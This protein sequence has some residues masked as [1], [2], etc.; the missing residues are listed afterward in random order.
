MKIVFFFPAWTPKPELLVQIF[1]KKTVLAV[2]NLI[3]CSTFPFDQDQT[4]F[5]Y[6]LCTINLRC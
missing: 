4:Y 5:W 1:L 2:P 3:S 6:V